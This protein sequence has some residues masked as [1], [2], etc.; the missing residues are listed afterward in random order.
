[1][2]GRSKN[3][4]L[5]EFGAV[6]NLI[7][8]AALMLD[9]SRETI[10]MSNS[11]LVQM[12]S[13]MQSELNGARVSDLIAGLVSGQLNGGDELVL[14]VNRRKRQPL[15]VL[16][17]VTS[18]DP[19]GQWL[20]LTLT[21]PERNRQTIIQRR[22]RIMQRIAELAR[23]PEEP[24]LEHAL[25]RA[26]E[27]ARDIFD[28]SLIAIYQADGE[29]PRLS[30]V[31][32][33][34]GEEKIFPDSMPSTDLIRL[35][36]TTLWTPGKRVQTEV[37]RASRIAGLSY[38]STT[39]LR[40]GKA[41]FGLLV[42]GDT[43]KDPFEVIQQ[44]LEIVG[45]IISMTAQ[46]FLLDGNLRLEI[47]KHEKLLTTHTA[48]FENSQEGIIV[49]DPGLTIRELNPASEWMLGYANWEVQGQPVDNILIGPERLIPALE[50]AC[51]GIPT[52]NIGNVNL[53][54]RNGQSFP[55]HLQTIPVMKEGKLLAVIVFLS[56]VSVHEQIRQR[57]QQL[58]HRAI[59]G[60]VTAVFAHEVRNPINNI[61]TGVQLITSRMSPDDPNLDVLNRIEG[62]CTRLNHLM[63]SVLAF[64]RPMEHKFEP[65]DLGI[66]LIRLLDR[67]RPRLTRVNV[68]L[69]LQVPDSIPKIS[70]DQ[71]ALEQVYTN[72]IGNAVEAM[73]KTGGTLAVRMSLIDSDGTLPQVEVTI[74]D[75][76]PGIP[77]EIK[78]RIFEPFV[79]NKLHG[80]GLGLAITKRIITAHHGNI[81]LDTFPGGTVFHVFMP[82]IQ[83]E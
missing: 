58:E 52:H 23:L 4:G 35:S 18:L 70:G 82:A 20:V 78:E 55:A 30:K 64:S 25:S 19:S 72:L 65:V 59:L 28:T 7:P 9:R 27:L 73:S 79:T 31:A 1:M 16:V 81:K 36:D 15:D 40:I 50:S 69:F 37:H 8:E 12:T 71:R 54:R 3:P 75:N 47:E 33:I 62:D 6:F 10:L 56:D 46:H 77:D 60:D 17:R 13:Y 21:P 14:P 11:A 5:S 83:G 67:W 44:A 39:P 68:E 49:L 57:T 74:S 80:T 53:H 24:D 34:K 22:D 41:L 26:V 32:S 38:A 45:A 48:V 63:E 76:G 51:Q 29:I 66:L 61:S 43:T 42:V 2:L